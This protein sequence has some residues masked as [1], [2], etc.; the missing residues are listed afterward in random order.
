M[1]TIQKHDNETQNILKEELGLEIYQALSDPKVL[2]VM[3]NEDG[4][5]WFG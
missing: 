2:E 5:V 3:L 4:T 1:K